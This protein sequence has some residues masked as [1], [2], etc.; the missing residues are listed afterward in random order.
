MKLAFIGGGNMAR[1]LIQGLL[2]HGLPAENIGVIEINTE[3]CTA[4]TQQFG[5]TTYTTPS[6]ALRDYDAWVLAVKPA[7]I[8]TLAQHLC[9]YLPTHPV[10]IPPSSASTITE[11]VIVSIA[12]GIRAADLSRW[13]GGYTRIVRAMPNTPALI[14]QGIT[15]AV[16]L[17]LPFAQPMDCAARDLANTILTAVGEVLWYEDEAQIDA[18]TA[19]SGSGPAY[20]FYFME[21]LEEAAHRLGFTAEQSKKLVRATFCGASQLAAQSDYSVSELRQQVT[22]PGGTT[23]A[24]LNV[25]DTQGFKAG[26]LKAVQ[27][28]HQRAQ[29]MGN[30]MG[31]L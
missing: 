29:D 5:V 10:E 3:V 25:F 8:R 18:L 11:P 9:T 26:V 12:A 4:L 30:E 27:A 22:S 28:A 6:A 31:T 15:G 13:L 2:Q 23:A 7:Q 1:A 17:P 19:I 24:A 21:A 20:V 16:M 14:G